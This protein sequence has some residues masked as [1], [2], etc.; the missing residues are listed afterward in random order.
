MM[1]YDIKCRRKLD[2]KLS[3]NPR[4]LKIGLEIR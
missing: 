2:S 4:L 3:D 1:E